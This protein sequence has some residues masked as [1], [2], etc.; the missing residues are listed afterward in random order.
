MSRSAIVSRISHVGPTRDPDLPG[1]APWW[2]ELPANFAR[3]EERFELGF[4]DRARVGVVAGT[5]VVLRTLGASLVGALALP[6]GYHPLEM[7]RSLEDLSLYGPMAESGDATQF[8]SRPPRHVPML[9][10]RA[11]APLFRPKIGRAHV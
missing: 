7:L 9:K 2:D 6:V 4:A 10:R 11:R 1:L 3:T 8:F 5:D